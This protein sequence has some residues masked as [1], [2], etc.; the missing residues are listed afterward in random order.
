P[1]LYE[2]LNPEMQQT[3]DSYV[4]RLQGL[5]WRRRADLLTDAALPFGED[6]PPEKATI[7]A[8]G[9]VTA[10]LERLDE[11]EVSEARQALLYLASLH[12]EHR[13]M[14]ERFLDENPEVR[15]EVE[16]GL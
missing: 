2:R 12:P 13:A 16:A 7:A 6:L 3:V 1:M 5:D 14:A 10:V 4:R 8:R 15:A 9:F 11:D